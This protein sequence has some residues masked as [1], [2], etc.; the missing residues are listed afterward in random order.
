VEDRTVVPARRSGF[1]LIELLVVI[2]IIAILASILFPVFAQAR[3]KARQTACISN[4]KQLST[5][6]LMYSQDYDELYPMAFGYYNGLGWLYPYIGDVP[7]NSNCTNGV[8][9]PS[10]TTGMSSYWA[11]AVQPY[12]KNYNILLCPSAAPLSAGYATAAGAP[13][14]VNTSLTYNGLLMC[15][16]QAGVATPAGLPMITE[17]LGKGGFTGGY[18]SNPVLICA[19]AA[20]MTCSYKFNGGANVNGGTS[21]WFNFLGTAGIHGNGQNYTYADGHT[22]FKALSLSV[23][24]AGRTNPNNEPWAVYDATGKPA[25]GWVIGGQLYYFRPDFAFP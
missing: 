8:C 4:N 15:Y 24:G 17:S 25:G 2:A 21:G 13:P 10:W 16:P 22:K 12:S 3:E 1:T 14:G 9:G 11:N 6:T 5:A 18:Q 7:Y 23:M 19:N 20:D